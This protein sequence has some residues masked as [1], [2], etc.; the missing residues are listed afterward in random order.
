MFGVDEG[1]LKIT[2][3]VLGARKELFE[4]LLK[5]GAGG[6]E[7]RRAC[8]RYVDS[9]RD[10]VKDWQVLGSVL[11]LY[12]RDWRGCNDL[13]SFVGGIV[14]SMMDIDLILHA[15]RN[16]I[17]AKKIHRRLRPRILRFHPFTEQEILGTFSA[18]YTFLLKNH[19]RLLRA[20]DTND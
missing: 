10:W 17:V 2:C 15:A 4:A 9:C 20:Q 14:A 8:R 7:R 18:I 19:Q 16:F 5:D 6:M 13:G 3:D 12:G 1:G 11:D